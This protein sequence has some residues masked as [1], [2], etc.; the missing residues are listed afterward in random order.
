MW[1]KELTERFPDFS[2][3]AVEQ[4]L[5]INGWG[6]GRRWSDSNPSKGTLFYKKSTA[7]TEEGLKFG[8]E[9][10]WADEEER[11]QKIIEGAI[12]FLE[13][14]RS[15]YGATHPELFGAE[16]VAARTAHLQAMWQ[17]ILA[18]IE[19]KPAATASM[20]IRD[21]ECVQQPAQLARFGS[22]VWGAPVTDCTWK[23]VPYNAAQ[24]LLFSEVAWATGFFDA[25]GNPLTDFYK[26]LRDRQQE[27]AL[28]TQ[29][30]SAA[31][32]PYV[33]FV[34]GGHKFENLQPLPIAQKQ[35]VLQRAILLT[36]KGNAL[37]PNVLDK[38]KVSADDIANELAD[39][40]AVIVNDVEQMVRDLTGNKIRE[41]AL[42][43]DNVGVEMLG[44]T[45]LTAVYM[46][47]YPGRKVT[48][49]VKDAAYLKSDIVQ[50]D[51]AGWEG[52]V[53]GVDGRS[54]F[55]RFGDEKYNPEEDVE[56]RA[57]LA[58]LNAG[59]SKPERFEVVVHPWTASGLLGS[60]IPQDLA[61]RI[62]RPQRM[63]I[64]VGEWLS[65]RFTNGI[66][67]PRGTD[68][69]TAWGYLAG[70][71]VRYFALLRMIKDAY[72][73]VI[74]AGR[75]D[76][77]IVEGGKQ[78]LISYATFAAR[79]EEDS[80]LSRLQEWLAQPEVTG[81]KAIRA[82]T[83]RG[84]RKKSYDALVLD[85]APSTLVPEL[86][87]G[88][89]PLLKALDA[90]GPCTWVD[91]AGGLGAALMEAGLLFP[92]VSC[93][94]VDAKE[95]TEE[96]FDPAILQ[97]LREQ[98][99]SV[100]VDLLSR[101]LAFTLADVQ[102]VD[103]RPNA[104]PPIRLITMLNALAYNEDPLAIV[105][106]L[107]N[108][109]DPGGVLLTN[110]YIPAGHPRAEELIRFYESLLEYLKAQ[111]VEADFRISDFRAMEQ[112]ELNN[113][114]DAGP[115]PE[116]SVGI[117]LRKRENQQLRVIRQPQSEPF[118]I[119]TVRVVTYQVA[120]YGEDPSQVIQATAGMEEKEAWVQGQEFLISPLDGNSLG[121]LLSGEEITVQAVASGTAPE[122]GGRQLLLRVTE[123]TSG[124]LP[125][126]VD[127]L[128][129]SR[130]V[131]VQPRLL[132]EGALQKLQEKFG[133]VDPLP[134]G[135]GDE[136]VESI[137]A[138]IRKVSQG[139]P[140]EGAKHLFV[141]N[142]QLVERIEQ[143]LRNEN[144][145]W[146]WPVVVI[147]MPQGNLPGTPS[148]GLLEMDPD[149]ILSYLFDVLARAD[150]LPGWRVELLRD[151][152]NLEAEHKL[153]FLSTRA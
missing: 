68:Y 51:L 7:G 75:F 40:S 145:D 147:G 151:A 71:G 14:R 92:N 72:I 76:G 47:M 29:K 24:A 86:K 103:L 114:G 23:N 110:L 36:V 44:A 57:L 33:Q 116:I 49:F 94:L 119:E 143:A 56:T 32:P 120:W 52:G 125:P 10:V 153:L 59:R 25:P 117:V 67:H 135:S 96:D 89:S 55:E 108:Q 53:E 140:A 1:T 2:E 123:T 77:E 111:G 136:V 101:S 146:S 85:Q 46:R 91:A 80:S 95:W 6:K 45:I 82:R 65:E 39:E 69:E 58:H 139:Q 8:D 144:P 50:R 109:L 127:Q 34:L 35:A 28:V 84:I 118:A 37:D 54:W 115:F 22:M 98:A 88:L 142:S 113:E 79:L 26:T 73:V 134:E 131:R 132:P 130:Q 141:V 38:L 78:G 41:I 81:G 133:K 90:Q 48:W 70:L 104:D 11:T 99:A 129:T 5:E 19:G 83:L 149:A 112:G 16:R 62:G 97:E 74:P 122:L 30:G 42:F 12:Q 61:D 20:T 9:K 4:Q 64:A 17:G 18:D 107:Y 63:L 105:A 121:K 138:Q 66:P 87:G 43:P 21:L 124:Y 128:G 27:E 93:R 60:A 100:G 150:A 31:L 126:E 152:F 106:N 13:K 3:S 102:S 148:R 137:L 15:Q